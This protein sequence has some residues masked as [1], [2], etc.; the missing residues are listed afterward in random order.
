MQ[1]TCT[2]PL[3]SQLIK[4]NLSNR[5]GIAE[6]VCSLISPI[7]N[8]GLKPILFSEKP[9]HSVLP[10]GRSKRFISLSPLINIFCK[11]YASVNSS[12]IQPPPLPPPPCGLLWGICP[13]CQSRG[14]GIC[15]F[16]TARGPD[17]CQTRGQPRAF[18]THTV[19]Y[20]N[21]TT[22]RILL[23]KQAD[24]LICQGWEKIEEVC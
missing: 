5:C 17:I 12:C 13:P 3:F 9:E 14:C 16:C 10:L 24:W 22:Q 20:Q 8:T 2:V 6:F 11:A 23:E 1:K 15:K 7:V 19:S 21:I 18:D 4:N